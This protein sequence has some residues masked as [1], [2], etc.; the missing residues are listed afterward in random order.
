M[1]SIAILGRA[2]VGK[3][4]L[5][6]RLVGKKHALVHETP[7][8]TRDCLEGIWATGDHRFQI[9]DTAGFEGGSTDMSDQLWALASA[10]MMQADVILWVIDGP[11]SLLPLDHE[12]SRVLRKLG[13]KKIVV[14]ANK[15]EG[16]NIL[17]GVG[18]A[19]ALNLGPVFPVSALHGT[20]LSDVAEH[21][22]VL[23]G[24]AHTL[25]IPEE[26]PTPIKLEDQPL[27]LAIIGRPNVGKSTYLNALLGHDRSLT[28]PEAGLTRD[29][30]FVDWMFEGK[31]VRLVDTAGIRR[32]SAQKGPI[33]KM[34]IEQA[35][36][37]VQFSHVVILVID[38]LSPLDHQELHLIQH[39][40]KEGRGLVLAL[41]KWDL[42]Q[43]KEQLIK[44]LR[45]DIGVKFP[46]VTQIPLVA[47]S[48]KNKKHLMAPIEEA[49]LVY[50]Q[51]NQRITTSKLNQWIIDV[52]ARNPAPLVQGRQNRL[53]YITQI[54][55]RPPTFTI[56]TSKPIALPKSYKRYL[57]NQIARAFDFSATPLRL[58]FRGAKNPFGD[59][60]RKG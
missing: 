13:H 30:I 4:T 55:T 33:E 37:A 3:S 43:N 9:L 54:N 35:L 22:A 7:G 34:S 56:Y 20:G 5:F 32:Q 40:L 59:K 46:D 29:A 23:G 8:L 52:E 11:K 17:E 2:N 50:K 53:K 42:I 26:S 21:I 6:N 24:D 12:L 14:L 16:Q 60:K 45:L 18:E 10:A 38:G 27:Q 25:V 44:D 58:L 28:G 48:A 39:V 49:F 41:N 51:W 36:R 57:R 47:I 19:E 1:I 15:C 31:P